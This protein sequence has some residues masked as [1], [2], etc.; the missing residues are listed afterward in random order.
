MRLRH[1]KLQQRSVV[2]CG[3]KELNEEGEVSRV[4]VMCVFPLIPLMKNVL[5]HL[6]SITRPIPSF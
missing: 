6:P 4:L 2:T 3:W 1:T 5:P